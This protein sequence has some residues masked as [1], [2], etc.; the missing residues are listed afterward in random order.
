MLATNYS[1]KYFLDKVAIDPVVCDCTVDAIRFIKIEP[2][3]ACLTRKLEKVCFASQLYFCL[4][5]SKMIGDEF[6][7]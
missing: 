7:R 1:S 6:R 4:L 3:Y 2:R 5:L